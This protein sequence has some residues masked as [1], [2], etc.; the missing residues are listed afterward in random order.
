MNSNWQ[1]DVPKRLE[2]LLDLIAYISGKKT[3][4]ARKLMAE[5]FGVTVRTIYRDLQ[6]LTRRGYILPAGKDSGIEVDG[7]KGRVLPLL[8][9]SRRQ[10]AAFQIGMEF[11]KLRSGSDIREEA[12][13]VA[14]RVR[15]VLHGASRAYFDA[16]INSTA[17]DPYLLHEVPPHKHWTQITDA[18]ATQSSLYLQYFVRSRAEITRRIVWPLGLVLYLD[19][20]NLIAFDKD[21][22]DFRQFT[23]DYIQKADKLAATFKPPD[24]FSLRQY[25][26]DRAASKHG[27]KVKVSFTSPSYPMARRAIPAKPLEEVDDGKHVTVTFNFDNLEFLAE[28]LLRFGQEIQ[29]LEPESLRQDIRAAALKVAGIYDQSPEPVAGRP[30]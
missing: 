30:A 21:K 8:R 5:E 17:L 15:S 7:E 26:A 12:E 11:I 3:L 9:L 1:E 24:G 10:A 13:K 20:W 18:I 16:L 14:D 22:N 23:L 27:T 19:H 28:Y 2:R 25:L 6:L 29:V 4:P